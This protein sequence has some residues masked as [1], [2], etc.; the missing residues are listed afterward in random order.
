MAALRETSTDV[1]VAA[2]TAENLVGHWAFE[3]VDLWEDERAVLMVGKQMAD[4]SVE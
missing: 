2:K 1:V 3:T 4:G